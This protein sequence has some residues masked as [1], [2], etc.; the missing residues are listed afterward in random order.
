V[1]AS[2]ARPKISDYDRNT[3]EAA[4]V[5][6]GEL[7]GELVGV[8]L[9]RADAKSVVKDALARGVDRAVHLVAEPAQ[10]LDGHVTAQALAAQI[11]RFDDVGLVLCTEG[12]S[13]TYA[14]ETGPRLGE[15]LGW[16]VVTNA[17]SVTVDDGRLHAVRVLAGE[18]ETVECDLPAV[19]T[20]VPEI[21]PAPIPGLRAVLAAGKKVSDRTTLDELALP[22][23]ARTPRT[24]VTSL[25]GFVAE[26]RRVIL[27]DGDAPERV[28]AL[29][30]G[31]AL[32]GVL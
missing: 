7:G 28:A 17:R 27:S 24:T 22:D 3:I 8:T 15:L 4:R 26:R 10:H 13:D 16:P 25:T 30:R 23:R 19:V 32:D 12:A 21:G 18:V 9:G 11:R 31:L 29:L 20:V 14:H 5:L 1:D 2:R 6:A